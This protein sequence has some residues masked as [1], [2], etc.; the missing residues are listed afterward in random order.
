MV[1]TVLARGADQ[2]VDRVTALVVA[3]VVGRVIAPVPPDTVQVIF[4]APVP[5]VI[6]RALALVLVSAKT[7]PMN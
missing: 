3:R 4:Q 2:A 5:P 6:V 1:L 7:L